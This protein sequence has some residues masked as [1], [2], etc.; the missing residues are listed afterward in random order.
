M[1]HDYSVGME[2][3]GEN[4]LGF[5]RDGLT[6]ENDI[7][8]QNI[9]PQ[10]KVEIVPSRVQK[11]FSHCPPSQCFRYLAQFVDALAFVLSTIA[12]ELPF[13]S[14]IRESD[15]GVGRSLFTLS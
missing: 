9:P 2:T 3:N 7:S 14:V 15:L 11:H 13:I 4:E 1:G 12:I 8:V 5:S 6:R 10:H